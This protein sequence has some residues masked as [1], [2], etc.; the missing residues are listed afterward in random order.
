LTLTLRARIKTDILIVNMNTCPKDAV[1]SVWHKADCL[2]RMAPS[3]TRLAIPL[4]LLDNLPDDA[5]NP[6]RTQSYPLSIYFSA[7]GHRLAESHLWF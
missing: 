2:L 6:S 5:Q 3:G 4:M 7:P 1:L